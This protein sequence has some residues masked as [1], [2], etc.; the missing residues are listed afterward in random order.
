MKMYK[1]VPVAVLIAAAG[2]AQA[3]GVGVR[4][5]T[6]GYGGDFGWQLAPTLNARLGYSAYSRDRDV[7]S[8][9]VNYQG[10]L[11]LSNLPLLVDFSP[12][13]PF[14]LTVGVIGNNNKID[15]TGTPAA[16]NT[17]TINGQT[18]NASDV[19][20]LSGKVKLGNSA[21]PYLGIGWGNVA[22]RGVNFYADLGVMFM[23]SPKAELTAACG[24]GTSAA[25]CAEIQ[26]RVEAEERA[27]EDKIKKY[28]YYPVINIGLTI[29]F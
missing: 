20:T 14:H 2:S 17:F 16:G 8:T 15:V 10:K 4:V 3:A 21:A 13:G 11:K 28:K 5:G 9:D 26:S 1:I 25:T 7:T 19:G 18:F 22:G 23:G 27:L 24:S 29:G 6:L 12:F